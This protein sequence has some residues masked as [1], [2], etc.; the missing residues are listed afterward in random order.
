MERRQIVL[1]YGVDDRTV[2]AFLQRMK[3]TKLFTIVEVG[4]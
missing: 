1:Y 2:S 4:I 3:A